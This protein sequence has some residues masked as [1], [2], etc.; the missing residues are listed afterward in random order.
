M[1]GALTFDSHVSASVNKANRMMGVIRRTFTH[2]D[3]ANFKYLFKA[4]VRPHLEYAHCVWKPHLRKHIN[5]IEGVQR[6]GSKLIPGLKH[7]SYPDR[8]RALGMPTLAY[9]RLRGDMIEVFKMA[10][11]HYDK[12]GCALLLRFSHNTRTRG[13]SLK[14]QTESCHRNKRLHF[15]SNRVASI[16]NS[17]PEAVLSE[18]NK[19]L[20]LQV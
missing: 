8:L 5:L 10:R 11:G 20:Q 2:L 7:L 19:C 3:S 4:L 1:D 12:E 18:C 15:Y 13:N 14:L 9:R 6:R 17:L 16:W